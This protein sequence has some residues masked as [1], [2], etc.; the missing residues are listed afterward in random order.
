M[1]QYIISCSNVHAIRTFV[2]Q[3]SRLLAAGDKPTCYWL[4][5]LDRSGSVSCRKLA[6]K[7]RYIL[8]QRGFDLDSYC[9]SGTSATEKRLSSHTW[10][11]RLSDDSNAQTSMH[12]A[13]ADSNKLQNYRASTHMCKHDLEDQC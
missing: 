11:P 12:G 2:E 4:A 3:Q 6:E 5:D 8:Q 9:G 1:R 7:C 10:V 13:K